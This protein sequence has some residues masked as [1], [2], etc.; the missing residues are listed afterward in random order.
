[1]ISAIFGLGLFFVSFSAL[2]WLL[3]SVLVGV[4][5][6]RR[7]RDG[8]GWFVLSVLI[9]P[10]VAAFLLLALGAGSPRYGRLTKFEKEDW[11]D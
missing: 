11:R 6:G 10:L 4:A 7:N 2:L 9:S 1:M 5:A 8:F 3:L